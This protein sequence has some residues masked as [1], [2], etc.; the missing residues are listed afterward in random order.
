[1]SDNEVDKLVTQAVEK[2]NL[3]IDSGDMDDKLYKTLNIGSDH[4]VY[5]MLKS[6]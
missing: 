6:D 3:R 2:L 4:G 1:M 5:T